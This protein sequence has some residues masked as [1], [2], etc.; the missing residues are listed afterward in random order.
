MTFPITY[1]SDGLVICTTMVLILA[2]RINYALLK[3]SHE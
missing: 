3:L 2:Q 1:H